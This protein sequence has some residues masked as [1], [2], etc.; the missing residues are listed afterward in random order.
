MVVKKNLRKASIIKP[1]CVIYYCNNSTEIVITS[2]CFLWDWPVIEST[3]FIFIYNALLRFLCVFCTSLLFFCC[4]MVACSMDRERCHC[5]FFQAA[6]QSHLFFKSI[7]HT[8]SL[9]LSSHEQGFSTS[10]SPVHL[11]SWKPV[12]KLQAPTQP[13]EIHHFVASSALNLDRKCW[14][15]L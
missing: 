10:G 11:C 8:S 9:L 13:A 14:A 1:L 4:S 7:P 12:R 3:F 5:F 2:C 6:P 15:L